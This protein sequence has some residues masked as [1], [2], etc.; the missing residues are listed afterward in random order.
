MACTD[1]EGLYKALLNTWNQ[2]DGVADA[3]LFSQE[4][5]IIG[6]DGSTANGRSEIQAHLSRIFR[7]HPTACY[8]GKV[9]EVRSLGADAA[10]L[11]AVAGMVPPGRTSL[12]PDRNAIQTVVASRDAS[13][14]WKIELFQ[15]TPAAFDGRPEETEKVSRELQAELQGQ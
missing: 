10:V 15:N 12:M 3:Q 2:R 13:N 7:D 14:S 4:G 8:V 5:S 1:V 11:R 9:R 6:F